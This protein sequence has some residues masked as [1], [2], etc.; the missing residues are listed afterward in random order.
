VRVDGRIVLDPLRPVVPERVRIAIDD[1]A[2][3]RAPWRTILFHKPRGVVTTRRDPEGRRT[4]FD[5]V[6]D[7]GQGLVAVGRLDLATSGLLLLT[8]DTR[9][10]D[11]I[12]DPANGVPRVY[13]V[14]VR[15][16]VTPDVAARLTGVTI[17]KHSKRET[18][19]IV[20]LRQ[21]RNREI[22]RMFES[23]GREVTRLK[24]V[25]IGG[26]ELGDLEPGAWR[27]LTRAE[28]RAAFPSASSLPPIGR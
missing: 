8:S 16:E 3:R 4:I 9:L 25:R 10:A 7:A 22:R 27:E 17:R 23:I 20:E 18:H 14:T 19:L 15:G 13:L 24:R 21:G 26:L 5:V 2:E 11:W 1:V 6:G 12:T 28:I